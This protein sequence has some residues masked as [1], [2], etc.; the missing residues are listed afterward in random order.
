VD[1]GFSFE[2]IFE[3]VELRACFHRAGRA[4]FL[5]SAFKVGLRPQPTG[6]HRLA[7][8]IV[9][10]FDGVKCSPTDEMRRYP[11]GI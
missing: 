6:G 8:A 5:R 1:Q 9:C 4:R 3:T 11:A 10:Q 7:P 2:W